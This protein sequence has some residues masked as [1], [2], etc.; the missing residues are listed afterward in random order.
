MADSYSETTNVGCGSRLIESIK[1]VG[2]GFLLV[3]VSVVVLFWNEGRSVHRQQ[4]LEEGAATVVPVNDNRVDPAN[5]AKLI[6]VAGDAKTVTGLADEQFD[7][8]AADALRLQRKVE[9]YQWEQNEKTESHKNFG[10]SEDRTTTYTYEK[11]WRDNLINSSNFKKSGHTN[12]EQIP[13]NSVTSNATDV[14]L[15]AFTVNNVVLEEL[16]PNKSVIPSGTPAAESSASK[17]HYTV[18]SDMLY[19]ANPSSP[20]IGDVRIAFTEVPA[21]PIS[22]IAPGP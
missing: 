2:I 11:V 17:P 16:S 14:K 18:S 6:H 9:M 1:G 4:A 7:I 10:G 5:E 8:K 21:G 3:G 13:Y 22:I 20:A 15:G 12:P 19:L